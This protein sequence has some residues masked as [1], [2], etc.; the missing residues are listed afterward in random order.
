MC[1]WHDDLHPPID[2]HI[3][4]DIHSELQRLLLHVLKQVMAFLVFID[5]II[6]CT[7]LLFALYGFYNIYGLFQT[8]TQ[9]NVEKVQ[10]TLIVSNPKLKS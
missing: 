7:L 4:H 6:S 9:R 5:C 10:M 2:I 1:V 8:I 3:M